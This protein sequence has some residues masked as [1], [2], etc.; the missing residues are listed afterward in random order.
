MYNISPPIIAVDF[1][2]DAS[3][4]TAW[5]VQPDTVQTWPH[6]GTDTRYRLAIVVRYGIPIVGNVAHYI[7][8]VRDIRDDS[9]WLRFD[10]MVIVGRGNPGQ[11]VRVPPVDGV[12]HTPGYTFYPSTLIY[13]RCT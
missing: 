7:T 5:T 11:A 9:V 1:G 10:G 6:G 3:E 4:T 8:D 2:T 12:L 13:V